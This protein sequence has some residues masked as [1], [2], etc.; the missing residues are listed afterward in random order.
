MMEDLRSLKPLLVGLLRVRNESKRGYGENGNN[1]VMCFIL[2]SVDSLLDILIK[3][4]WDIH[5]K[6]FRPL[7]KLI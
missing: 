6:R 3:I 2:F 7:N 5:P 4:L 1:F